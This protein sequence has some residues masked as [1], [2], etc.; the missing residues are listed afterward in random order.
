MIYSLWETN[1]NSFGQPCG[2]FEFGKGPYASVRVRLRM[3]SAIEVT[4]MWLHWRFDTCEVLWRFICSPN[5]VAM[6]GLTTSGVSLGVFLGMQI[7][8]IFHFAGTAKVLYCKS[9][10]YPGES[11]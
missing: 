3:L 6:E 7:R 5:N 1:R 9:R 4:E 11:A 8:Y 10:F 2:V